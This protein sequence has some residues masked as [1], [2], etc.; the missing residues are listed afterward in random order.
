MRRSVGPPAASIASIASRSASPSQGGRLSPG[1]AANRPRQLAADS[2][3]FALLGAARVCVG[4]RA[5]RTL[6]DGL[7]VERKALAMRRPIAPTSNDPQA[8]I[9]DLAARTLRRRGRSDALLAL[10][11]QRVPEP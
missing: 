11:G 9:H 7:D 3:A 8:A 5:G 10:I 4:V 1:A 2:L 6:R